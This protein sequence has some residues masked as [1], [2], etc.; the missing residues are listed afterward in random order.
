MLFS[1]RRNDTKLPGVWNS[2]PVQVVEVKPINGGATI[3]YKVPAEDELLYVIAEYERNGK[4]FNEKASVYNNTLRIEGFNTVKP[5]K[6]KIYKVNKEGQRSEPTEIEFTPLESLVSI[7]KNSLKLDP[8][9]G[10]VVAKWENPLAT[11]LGVRLLWKDSTGKYVTRTMYFSQAPKGARAFRG[12]GMGLLNVG[13]SFEDKW[14][15]ISD[16]VYYSTTPRFEA[17][18]AKPYADYRSTIPY[19]NTTNYGQ[20][21][22]DQR[23]FATIYDGVVNTALNGWLTL[24]GGPSLS[25]TIDLKQV[26]KLSRI[27]LHG[28]HIN[29]P[30]DQANIQQFEMWGTNKVD[31]TKLSDRPYWLDELSVRGG[32]ISGINPTEV[33]PARTFKDDW[34]YLGWHAITRYDL[35]SPPDQTGIAYISTNGS[36]YEMPAEAPPVRYIRIFVRQVGNMMPPPQ[37]NYFSLGEITVYGDNTVPQQ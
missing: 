22:S 11:E 20:G 23:P 21:T 36:E 27:V 2:A 4:T 15:N 7:A 35:M 18:I 25:F 28:Y 32:N 5:V 24:S 3:S 16:T 33:L 9:F 14:G 29:S 6:A 26:V 8:G 1:C 19:D 17:L 31:F 10:G 34:T 30:Y 13:V 37:S 12:F